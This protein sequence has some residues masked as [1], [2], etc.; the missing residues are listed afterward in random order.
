MPDIIHVMG[1]PT[2]INQI[3][4]SG[5]LLD[6]MPY[7]DKMPHFKKYAEEN[8]TKILKY[9]NAEGQLYCFPPGQA[10]GET[11]RRGWMYRRDIFEKHNIPVPTTSDELYAVMKQ[12]K[13]LYPDSYPYTWRGG[14]SSQ[15][16]MFVPLWGTGWKA[17]YD[18]D[19]GVYKYGPIE[20]AFKEMVE[21]VN[22]AYKD[23]LLPPDILSLNTA[24]WQNLVSTSKVF[25]IT[26]YL[27]RI[28]SFN[29]AVREENPDFTIAY[30]KPI[31]MGS[32]GEQKFTYSTI[33]SN[34]L[35][36]SS[37]NKNLD[38]TFKLFD[39][40]YS[41]EGEDLLSWGKEGVTYQV[42][43]GK[44]KFIDCN[45]IA[46]IRNKY[47]FTTYGTSADFDYNSHMSTFSPELYEG[48]MEGVKYD[49]PEQPEPAFTQEEYE[50]IVHLEEALR[51]HKEEAVANFFIGT[52][53]LSEWDQY[54][55]EV[56]NLKVDRYLELH[57]NANKR[58][59]EHMKELL[60][61]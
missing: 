53:S 60:G 9:L 24:G 32:K 39:F 21:W 48:Y 2:E 37:T 6:L 30:M 1:G 31:A 33:I 49:M 46:D 3:G 17:Y 20:D 19:A 40:Y 23:E 35:T 26:D 4:A 41:D 8:P 61:N 52:R 11:N 36:I 14:L 43:D 44:R 10:A 42:V 5:A 50:E 15:I 56:K 7:M 29:D 54:V 28:D 25:I 18:F 34:A 47:G 16:E 58:M 12:L 55:Q 27:T 38:A 22:K 51:K 59:Q 57:N 45:S 13:E